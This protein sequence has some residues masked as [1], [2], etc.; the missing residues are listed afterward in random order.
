MRF[1]PVSF[2]LVS[3]EVIIDFLPI[4][5]E[6][7]NLSILTASFLSFID[8]FTYYVISTLRSFFKTV[9]LNF[10]VTTDFWLLLP[11][12]ISIFDFCTVSRLSLS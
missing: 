1:L 4:I 10:E 9:T 8:V 11:S 2:G 3:L 5:V 7:L 6:T 12:A